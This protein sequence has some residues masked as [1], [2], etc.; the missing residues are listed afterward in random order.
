MWTAFV[1]VAVGVGY[2]RLLATAVANPLQLVVPFPLKFGPS[3]SFAV[4]VGH[5]PDSLSTVGSADVMRSDNTP[6][7]IE[8][9]RGKV[10]EDSGKPSSHKHW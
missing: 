5:N 4:G 9:Q 2:M 1:F 7:R 3:Q 6:S 10:T 8:P